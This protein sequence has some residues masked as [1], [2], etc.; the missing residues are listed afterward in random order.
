VERTAAHPG[1]HQLPGRSGSPCRA[2]RK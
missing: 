1:A 2:T